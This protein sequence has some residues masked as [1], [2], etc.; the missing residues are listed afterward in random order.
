MPIEVSRPNDREVRVVR[1]FNAPRQLVWDAH[2]KPELMQKWC[3]GYPGWT[4]PICDMDVREGGKYRWRWRSNEDGSEFGFFGTFSEVKAPSRLA[5]DQYY[6]PGDMDYAMP[7]G[8]P[9]LVALDLSEADGVTTLVCTMTFVSKEVC[10]SA[11][12]TGM[13]DGMEVGYVRIDELFKAEA[14]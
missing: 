6:D 14:V 2:T 7:V 8:D 4:L 11:V 9:C 13:T 12:A 10:E 1:Q 3:I 5:H